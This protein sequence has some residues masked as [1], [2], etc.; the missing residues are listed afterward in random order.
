MV[1]GDLVEG[2]INNFVIVL[3]VE[4]RDDGLGQFARVLHP[5]GRVT[6]V[7]TYWLRE[8]LLLERCESHVNQ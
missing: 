8:V 6:R 7:S 5:N 1:S 3:S 2:I 4:T